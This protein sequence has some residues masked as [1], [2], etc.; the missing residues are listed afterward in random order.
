VITELLIMRGNFE[1]MINV[2]CILVRI[3]FVFDEGL[4]A[5]ITAVLTFVHDNGIKE[6]SARNVL[7]FTYSVRLLLF[8]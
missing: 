3:A 1:K 4:Q 2:E 6:V 7:M 5:R 8:A